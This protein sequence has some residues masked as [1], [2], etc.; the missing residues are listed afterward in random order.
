MKI[1][2]LQ[3]GLLLLWV[4]SLAQYPASTQPKRIIRVI[5]EAT[6][7]CTPDEAQWWRD[8]KTAAEA[9]KEST[10]GK[11]QVRAFRDLLL[12][13][14]EKSYRPPVLDTRAFVLSKTEPGYSDEAR[15]RKISGTVRLSAELQGDG[16]VGEVRILKGLGF[17]LDDRAVDSARHVIF[18][19]AVKDRKFVQSIVLMENHFVTY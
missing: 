16:F 8:L 2:I 14:E 19:P 17:G 15:A 12:T 18:L 11:K 6:E 13:G 7:P 9:V 3:F 1:L 10:G 4:T 5:P